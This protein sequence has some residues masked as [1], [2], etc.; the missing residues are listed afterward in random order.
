MASITMSSDRMAKIANMAA[1]R[2]IAALMR[3]EGITQEQLAE[4]MGVKKQ[5]LSRNFNN[6][7]SITAKTLAKIAKALNT[8][9]V[10]R[11]ADKQKLQEDYSQPPMIINRLVYCQPPE[12]ATWKPNGDYVEIA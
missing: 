4:K 6:P 11:V 1:M 9:L 8:P 3:A 7:E 5:S 2:D 10:I 12:I